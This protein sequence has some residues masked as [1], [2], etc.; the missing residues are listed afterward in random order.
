[1]S[2]EIG[3][4]FALGASLDGSFGTSFKAASGHVR[5]IT[6]A[7]RDMEQSPVGRLGASLVNQQKAIRGTTADLN[8]ARGVLHTLRAQS[9]A[10]GGASGRLALQLQQAENDV[11]SLT[12]RLERQNTVFSATRA[13][14]ATVS[15]SLQGLISD[16]RQLRSEISAQEHIQKQASAKLFAAQAEDRQRATLHTQLS[17]VSDGERQSKLGEMLTA[18]QAELRGLGKELRA[19]ETRLAALR[20]KSTSAGTSSGRLTR[21]IAQAEDEVSALTGKLRLVNGAYRETVAA[22]GS[23]GASIRTLTG[24]YNALSESLAKAQGRQAALDANMNAQRALSAQRGELTGRLLGAAAQS[25]TVAAPL[26]LSVDAE[27][28]FADLTKHMDGASDEMKRQTFDDAL[29]LSEQTGKSFNEVITIMA[30]GAQAGLGKTREEMVETATQALQM[31]IAWDVSVERAGSSLANWRAAMQMTSE[32]SRHT[33]DVINALSNNMNAKAGEIDQIFTRMGPM[34]KGQ[35]YSY[36]GIAAFSAAFKAAGAEVEVAGTALKNFS[37]VMSAGDAALTDKKNAVFKAMGLDPNELQKEM[38]TDAEGVTLK[39]IKGLETFKPEQRLSAARLLFGEESIAAIA[40]LLANIGLIDQALSIARGKVDGSTFDEYANRMKTTK[41]EQ[42]KFTASL[43]NFGIVVGN[44]LLPIWN[45]FVRTI[46]GGVQ[47]LTRFSQKFPRLTGVLYAGVAAFTVLTAGAVFLGLVLNVVRMSTL[48]LRR[49]VLRLS[50]SQAVATTSTALMTARTWAW[51][52][53][54]WAGGAASRF[55]AG[56]IRSLLLAS[57]VGAALVA[58]GFAADTI[59]SNWSTIGPAISGFW[60]DTVAFFSGA[61]GRITGFFTSA[62][63][64]VTDTWSRLGVFFSIIGAGI[65]GLLSPY[66]EKLKTLFADAKAW[67]VSAW[68][69]VT[70]F[71]SG[72]WDSLASGASEAWTWI[73]DVWSSVTSFF[74]G[75][76][77]G[78]VKV[79][80]AAWDGLCAFA[81]SGWD[82][83]T[84]LWTGVTGFF[85]GIWNGVLSIFSTAWDYIA[86]LFTW[87]SPKMSWLSD[88]LETIGNAIDTVK[89]GVGDAW[90]YVGDAWNTAFSGW[91]EKKPQDEKKAEEK[92]TETA[93]GKVKTATQEPAPAKPDLK[94]QPVPVHKAPAK[95]SSGVDLN[96][97]MAEEEAAK[98]KGTSGRRKEGN[99][100]LTVVTLDSG[101]VF[102]TTFIP[103]PGKQRSPSSTPAVAGTGRGTS[104]AATTTARPAASPV[105]SATRQRPVIRTAT[106]PVEAFSAAGTRLVR[107]LERVFDRLPVLF[108]LPVTLSAPEP[109]LPRT[110]FLL[111]SQRKR[112]KPEQPAPG[113]DAVIQIIQHFTIGGETNAADFKRRLTAERPAF[114]SIVRKILRDIQSNTRRTAHAQ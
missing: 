65:A 64:T 36:E 6:Q 94:A 89:Q 51:N 8:R 56:G 97:F 32:E 68:S 82:Y 22:S 69:D 66:T 106:D 72:L 20:A 30:S 14:A 71:F 42:A 104:S 99:G 35:G 87:L 86:G 78:A 28:A 62:W 23:A 9:D 74:S 46:T 13:R 76:W 93:T 79:A 43:A 41:T 24:R 44:T 102:H 75:V 5:G 19:A 52:A 33:S 80:A 63:D 112:A 54:C 37:G 70:A 103:A 29:R 2:R 77:S 16:Y 10:A 84:G 95:P 73:S 45:G 15:G 3:V 67:C 55:F 113:G 81:A 114:E 50:G 40:P 1:M 7:I 60:N 101:N 4:S 83:M 100:P 17:G 91:G 108:G 27:D 61:V 98:K 88:A 34:L 48:S 92:P 47:S 90:D 26:K 85:S 109:V 12:S 111:D 58:L 49:S 53:A 25:V 31:A 18:Q 38:L 96:K 39:V 105:A 11:S 110:P 57:G 59:I 107:G 21:Q